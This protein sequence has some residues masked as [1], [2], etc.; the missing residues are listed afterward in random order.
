MFCIVIDA[1]GELYSMG[2]ED[3]SPVDPKYVVLIKPDSEVEG[4][5]NPTSRTFTPRPQQLMVT[6]EYFIDTL[7]LE[8]EFENLV[9]SS[10]KPIRA[11]LK[12]L[13]LLGKL[14]LKE[15]R[16]IAFINKLEQAGVIGVG[17][18]AVILNG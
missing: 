7:L 12:R 3:P 17:R 16:T 15:D 6:V 2:T 11:F 10:I 9:D 18:A 5:W 1:T 8:A 13:Q 14:D 4:I